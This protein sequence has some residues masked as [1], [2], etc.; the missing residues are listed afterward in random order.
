ME[1]ITGVGEREHVTST[2]HRA[3]FERIIGPD[4]YILDANELLEPELQSNNS[5][6]IRSGMLSHHGGIAEVKKNTY[7]EVTI[8]N[9][10][11]DM[12]RID[13]VVARYER[14]Q[15]TEV[16]H[17]KWVAI[18]GEPS[19]GTPVAP[20]YIH[21]NMQDGDV[22]DD[23]PIFEV[24]LDGIQVT[25]VKKLLPV[26]SG[27]LADLNSNLSEL[28][29]KRTA[30][31]KVNVSAGAQSYTYITISLPAGYS[32]LSVSAVAAHSTTLCGTAS[33]S[34]N[35]VYIPYVTTAA[36]TPETFSAEIVLLKT[37]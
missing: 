12:K 16:E 2:Q 1:F 27:G 37:L 36:Q 31:N 4:S 24:H 34:G 19:E 25:D 32:V 11:Q 22:T 17:M 3:I 23:C 15:E 18:Q 26:V 6:K 28:I 13:L 9:G 29:I 33:I 8:T 35:R 14:N 5:L 20:D 7:D 21:G 30:T 10:T